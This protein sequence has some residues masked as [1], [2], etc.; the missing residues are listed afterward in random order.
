LALK[1]T[2][3]ER[4]VR[5]ENR[6]ANLYGGERSLSSGAQVH[7]SGDVSAGADLIECKTTGVPGKPSKL[8]GFMKEFE[9]ITIEAMERGRIPVLCLQYYCPDSDIANRDGMVEVSV[10]LTN[11]DVHNAKC[12]D[13][14][15]DGKDT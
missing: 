7:D 12:R 2:S 15:V 11:D 5:Q 10:R 9:K 13:R 8:P 1:G 14:V 4:S 3:K 6:I